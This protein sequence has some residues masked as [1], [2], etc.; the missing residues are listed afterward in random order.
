[1]VHLKALLLLAALVFVPT[2]CSAVAAPKAGAVPAGERAAGGEANNGEA[3]AI[4]YDDAR[5]GYRIEAPGP[6]TANADGSASYIGAQE[7]LEIHLLQGAAAAPATAAAA[8]IADL[9]ANAPGFALVSGP[10]AAQ[11]GPRTLQKLVYRWTAGTSAVT[12]KPIELVSV[13]YYLPKNSTTLAVLT[14]GVTAS[15][16]D[17]QGADDTAMTFAWK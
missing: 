9:T 16:Y 4:P 2:A 12:G 15:Q 14:Y 5:S 17:P 7:R 8:D 11:V 6:M 1:M 3:Q 10:T 13:R